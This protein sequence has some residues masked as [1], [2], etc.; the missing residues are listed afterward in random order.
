MKKYLTTFLL[1]VF[2]IL[3]LFSQ[4][5][6][7]FYPTDTWPF[8]YESFEDGVVCTSNNNT[9][10]S[11][12]MNVSVIDQKL[13]FING[14][15]IMVADMMRLYTARI[16]NDIYINIAGKLYHVLEETDDGAVIRSM[17]VDLDQMNKTNIGYGVSSSTAS[18]QNLSGIALESSIGNFNKALSNKEYG[19]EIPVK[20]K[21][22]ILYSGNKIVSANKGDVLRIPGLDKKE[23]K[24]FFKES[25]IKWNNPES[26]AIVASYLSKTVK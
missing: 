13:Y 8:I 22:Y 10:L 18:T 5:K 24:Q 21:N 9:I 3:P 6:G 7:F 23:A 11:G 20:G 19:K 14:D 17:V 26:L 15:D 1:G 4:D 25:K 16:K 12:R 2:F